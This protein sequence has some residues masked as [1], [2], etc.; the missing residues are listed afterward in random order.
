MKIKDWVGKIKQKLII[1]GTKLDEKPETKVAM[2]TINEQQQGR[3]QY[4]GTGNNPGN[5][6]NRNQKY[7]NRN[8]RNRKNTNGNPVKECGLC[9]LIKGKDRSQEYVTMDFKERHQNIGQHAIYPNNCLPWMM[10]SIDDRTMVLENNKLYCKFCLRSLREGTNG[11]SCGISRHTRNSGYNGMC[12]VREFD[13]HVTLC[14]RHETVNRNQHKIYKTS[15]EWVQS[16]K[17]QQG[18]QT[19]RHNSFLIMAEESESRGRE[20]LDD[21]NDARKEIHLKRGTDT[22]DN[23]GYMVKEE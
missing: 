7:E 12:S 8:G 11:S 10:L 20:E 16:L 5:K 22:S 6:G 15:L 2:V 13:R 18:G 9:N 23:F 4:N 19:V 3:P 1:R 14:K 21:L 17:P